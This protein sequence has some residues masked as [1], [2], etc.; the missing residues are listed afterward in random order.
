ML[1][2]YVVHHEKFKKV[3]QQTEKE[4]LNFEISLNNKGPVLDVVPVIE[5]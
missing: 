5:Q 4:A 1:S 2:Y 3:M